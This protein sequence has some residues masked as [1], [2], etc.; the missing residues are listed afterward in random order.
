MRYGVY[1]IAFCAVTVFL[2]CGHLGLSSYQKARHLKAEVKSLT[3]RTRLMKWQVGELQRKTRILNRVNHFMER[4]EDEKLT[5]DKWSS[6]EVH[7]QDALAFRELAQIVEQ[8]IHN[9]NVYF[10]PISFHA[11]LSNEKRSE[12]GS[13]DTV[14]PVPVD[15]D[16]NVET[17][18]DVTL[19]LKGTFVV[20][21]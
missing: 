4:A 7:I 19:A 6:Y 2:V 16:T 5:P 8:C 11:A 1:I 12:E 17:S 9:Q 14:E 10:K 21:H 20:R 13:F 15:A 18:A 3:M